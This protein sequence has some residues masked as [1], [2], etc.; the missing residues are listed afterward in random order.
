M[1]RLHLWAK[2]DRGIH[3]AALPIFKAAVE[4]EPDPWTATTAAHG[5]ETIAGPT[6]GQKAWRT[7]LS[8]PQPE[9]AA[10]AVLSLTE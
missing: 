1:Q 2:Q 7:L 3:G 8:H 5:I 9:M 4:T 6:E 10:R